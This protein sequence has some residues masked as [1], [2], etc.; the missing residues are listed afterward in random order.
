VTKARQIAAA[1]AEARR[2]ELAALDARIDRAILCDKIAMLETAEAR[3][4]RALAESAIK[5]LIA[6][7]AVHPGDYAGE[8]TLT[9]Q[10]IADPTL[11]PLAL[12]KTIFRAG[13]AQST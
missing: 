6:N 2:Y 9:A 5:K 13:P 8:F 11:I 10:F 3:R 12:T 4:Q 7:G 1:K